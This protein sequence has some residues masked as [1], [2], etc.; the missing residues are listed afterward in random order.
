MKILLKLKHWQ[1]FILLFVPMLFPANTTIGQIINL[2]WF[3][4]FLTWV[5]AIAKTAYDQLKD[6]NN[7]KIN[8]FNFSVIFVI[9]WLTA[10][11]LIFDGGY[12]INQDNYQEFGNSIW[13]VL[14][15]H[16]YGMWSILYIFYFAAKMLMSVIEGKVVGFDKSLGYFF[17]FWFFPIGI[18]FIQPKAQRLIDKDNG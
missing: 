9:G 4:L 5:Y 6:D 17:G 7:L 13:I 8:Y 14:P 10:V 1:L 16:L 2:L 18:W 12:N 15:L 3:P 11:T